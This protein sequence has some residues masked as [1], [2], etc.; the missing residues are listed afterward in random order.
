LSFSPEWVSLEYRPPV[1]AAPI[2][3]DLPHL[4]LLLARLK[5][6]LC[7]DIDAR[8]RA[9]HD[10][11]L[12]AFDAMKTITQ[13]GESCDEPALAAALSMTLDE[14]RALLDGLVRSGHARRTAGASHAEPTAVSLTLRGRLV[15]TRAGRTLDRELNRRIGSVLSPGEIAELE[16]A[17]AALRRS[18]SRWC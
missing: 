10:L 7:A 11:P 13:P 15:L 16:D 12:E 2:P 6:T 8:L 9:E 4:F 14:A 5:A 1:A 3:V 17:L 18:A